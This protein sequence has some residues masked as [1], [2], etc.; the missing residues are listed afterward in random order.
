MSPHRSIHKF[1]WTSPDEKTQNKNDH[2]LTESRYHSNV[3][4]VRLLRGP[5][6]NTNHYLVVAKVRET[7]AAS[8][9]T[10][11]RFHTVRFTLKKPNEVEG[12]EQY[13][14]E[15]SNR[16]A[17]LE[18]SD[19]AVDINRAWQAIR[20]STKISAK[21]GLG[22]YEPKKHYHGSTKDAQNY[23]VRREVLYNIFKEFG[24]PMKLVRLI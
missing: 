21:E 13:R 6:C 15:I 1:T 9:Q 16:F 18:N 17:A 14:V 12:K 2:N 11:H 3:F 10:M 23:S 4:D 20:E 19:T 8:K 22:Y 5:D 24:V 7:L